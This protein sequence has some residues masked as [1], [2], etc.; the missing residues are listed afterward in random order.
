M[1]FM[2]NRAP[3][4]TSGHMHDTIEE[5]S[6]LSRGAS[7][8]GEGTSR[9]NTP[10]DPPPQGYFTSKYS[11]AAHPSA[12]GSEALYM[13]QR[14]PDD[15]LHN[16]DPKRDVTIDRGGHIFTSRGIV[17]VGCLV[18]LVLVLVGLF[19]GY[20]LVSHLLFKGQSLLGGFNLGGINATGQVP[21]MPYGKFG[22]IDRDTPKSAYYKSSYVNP[23]DEWQ[24]VFSDEFEVEGRSF[25]PGD[26]PYW[27]AVNLWYW[28]TGD[29][30]WYDPIAVTTSGGA[31]HMTLT[32]EDPATN[33]NFSYRSGM[34]QS[35]N[36][37]CFTGG[38]LEVNVRLPGANN[39][40]GLWPAVW[41]MGNL[42]RAGYGA[43]LEGMW[44]YSYDECD[45][46]TLPGQTYPNKLGPASA[47]N[48]GRDGGTLSLLSGQR[49]SRCTCPGEQHPGP[50]RKKTNEWV[51]RAAPELDIFEAII[52]TTGVNGPFGQSSQSLQV[53]PFDSGYEWFNT[54]GNAEFIDPTYHND[55]IG[56]TRQETLS[57]L[58]TNRQDCYEQTEGCFAVYGFE[59]QP[60]F[61]DG[62]IAWINDD[63]LT[64]RVT[65]AG[66][67]PNSLT[68]V[69]RRLIP[70]EPMY[71]I[72]NLGYSEDFG[73][74]DHENM[75]LPATMSVDYVRVYQPKNNINWGCD[76]ED[77]PTAN[78]IAAYP[79]AYTNANFTS[80]G[81]PQY[82]QTLP[83]NKLIDT[84]T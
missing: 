40:A 54:S 37:F 50:F 62:Y 51:G 52:N 23:G 21:S 64:W 8:H 32:P 38:I 43:S 34:I 60:G 70:V 84:C 3:S 7:S 19:A 30:E 48:T 49:L 78:Y 10:N 24:L 13:H 20:P 25:Y 69:G 18:T 73:G 71:I 59:Y 33:H 11:L 4:Q 63:A 72:M 26:D 29:I 31:V 53:A 27:E 35:W 75:V 44:P 76:P 22:L 66:L 36:K 12:W 77:Y 47:L 81:F 79:E 41:S 80:F 42:G 83:K 68:E 82:N 61:E 14:E 6:F 1:A 67:G 16:P 46:G 15:Y 17:N 9:S 65:A 57:G 45:I 39:V 74:I 5:T 2:L 56:N 58:S 28:Q 55:F